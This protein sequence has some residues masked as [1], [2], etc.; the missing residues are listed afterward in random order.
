MLSKMLFRKH[1]KIKFFIIINHLK[2]ISM[3]D[4][5]VATFLVIQK[6]S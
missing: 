4:L 1:S 2:M 6:Y 3:C 5:K